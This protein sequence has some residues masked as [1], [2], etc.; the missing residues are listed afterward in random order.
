MIL[1]VFLESNWIVISPL[2]CILCDCILCYFRLFQN[3]CFSH[4]P[5]IESHMLRLKRRIEKALTCHQGV[6]GSFQIRV[7]NVCT[8][9]YC[10][11][12]ISD[13]TNYVTGTTQCFNKIHNNGM[14]F[15]LLNSNCLLVIEILLYV[16]AIIIY[17]VLV[18]IKNAVGDRNLQYCQTLNL[19]SIYFL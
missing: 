17:Y 15:V 4:F 10:Q 5:V 11:C 1:L 18:I 9:N 19:N 8:C 6:V 16:L 7:L 14:Y 2:S 12:I 13:I 3:F